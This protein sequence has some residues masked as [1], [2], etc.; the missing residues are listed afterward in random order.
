MT[1][2]PSTAGDGQACDSLRS[3]EGVVPA[4][5]ARPLVASVWPQMWVFLPMLLSSLFHNRYS[6]LDAGSW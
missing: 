3:G 6:F 4:A 2:G 1:V 5:I